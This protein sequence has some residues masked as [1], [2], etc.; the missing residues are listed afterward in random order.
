EEMQGRR[1]SAGRN[2]FLLQP[3]LKS[4]PGCLRDIQ[5]LRNAS[6]II[7]GSRNLHALRDLDVIEWDDIQQLF[8]ANDHLVGVRSMLHFHHGHA[9]DELRLTDQLWLAD[10]LGYS[11]GGRLLAVEHM[12]RLHYEKTLHVHQMV[13][14]TVNRMRGLGYV[15]R[16]RIL[17]KSRRRMDDDFSS[18]DGRVYLANRDFWQYPDAPLR[19]MKMFRLA[20]RR[21]LR[22]GLELQREIKYRAHILHPEQVRQNHEIARI[23]LEIIGDLGKVRNILEDMHW[24]GLLG[25]YMPEFG[26]LTCHMQFNSYHQYTVDEHTL[27]ALGM[28]DKVF[29]GEVPGVAN[30]QQILQKL[31]RPDLLMLSLLLHDVGKFMGS[32]HVKRGAMM[33]RMIAD[34][35][36]LDEIEEDL[37]HFLVDQHVTLSDATRN[38]NIHDPS[39]LADLASDM[40]DGYRLDLLYCLTFADA[41]AVGVGVFTGWQEALLA[42]LHEACRN[43]IRWMTGQGAVSRP[44]RVRDE[45]HALGIAKEDA[46]SFLDQMGESYAYQVQT[47]EVARHLELLKTAKAEGYALKHEVQGDAITVDMASLDRPRLLSEVAA[48]LTGNGF[49]VVEARTWCTDKGMVLHSH[50]LQSTIPTAAADPTTWERLDRDLR[51]VVAKEADPADFIARRR[52]RITTDGPVDSGFHEIDVRIDQDSALSATVIDVRVK[53]YPGLLYDLCRIIADAGVE[54]E[55]ASIATF[56]DV[57]RDAFYVTQDSQKLEGRVALKLRNALRDHL[58]AEEDKPDQGTGVLRY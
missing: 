27:I 22:I 33:V 39:F 16:R 29:T 32:G 1:Q 19:L 37:V 58:Q 6:Y 46:A 10:Q 40:G 15:G 42:E 12:M 52:S 14:I 44:Q 21:G 38:R 36:G 30:M 8:A 26:R 5:F 3:N 24:S 20:Q 7:S 55:Y 45:L 53:D 4:N 23:F 17:I 56:G 34:R 57:A 43:E 11:R 25:A 49:E 13:D 9:Q 41:K 47:H 48:A 18:I 2:L 54:I 28:I 35:M 50:R 51:K 31:D